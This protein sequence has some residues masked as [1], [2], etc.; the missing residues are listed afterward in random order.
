[1]SCSCNPR[2]H[3]N[4]IV[5]VVVVLVLEADLVGSAW[6]FD[7]GVLLHALNWIRQKH[8]HSDCQ[9][10]HHL[11]VVEQKTCCSHLLV[12]TPPQWQPNYERSQLIMD[13]ETLAV[14]FRY[15]PQSASLGLSRR[16]R[17]RCTVYNTMNTTH[18]VAERIVYRWR[19]Q[20]VLLN[21]GRGCLSTTHALLQ[22]IKS[23]R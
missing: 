19:D 17:L 9:L 14:S 22:F 11:N 5:G 10:L 20:H 3:Q 7:Y 8:G 1:V 21:V 12:K 13:W 2:P 4:G 16:A 23:C 18:W 6:T 15:R